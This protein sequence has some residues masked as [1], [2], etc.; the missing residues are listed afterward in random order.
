MVV[1]YV[2]YIHL[3]CTVHTSCTYVLYAQYVYIC[4][5]FI[6]TH[7]YS[8]MGTYKYMYICVYVH[9]C[10]CAYVCMCVCA[11]NTH[12]AGTRVEGTT[13]HLHVLLWFHVFR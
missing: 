8:R 2:Q 7:T 5:S 13:P 10:V 12:G 6:C 1:K 4:I 9:M 11:L 3:A